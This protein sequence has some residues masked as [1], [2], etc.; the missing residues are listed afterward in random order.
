MKCSYFRTHID[1]LFDCDTPENERIELLRHSLECPECAL[2]YNQIESAAKIVTPR[3][4]V[5]ASASLKARILAAAAAQN[6]SASEQV[7]PRPN[8]PRK[9]WFA[10]WYRPL[11]AVAACILLAVLILNPGR[12]ARIYAAKTLFRNAA[13]AL[14]QSG[15]FYM[16]L[17][18]RTRPGE[19][20]S[21]IN[22]SEPFVRHRMWVVPGIPSLWRLDK[23]GRTAYCDGQQIRM[24]DT[25][26]RTGWI[27]PLSASAI[28]D[29]TLLLDPRTLL[30]R[31]E[32]LAA[33]NPRAAY[34]K[35]VGADEVRLTVDTPAKGD[36]ANDRLLNS[37][38]TESDS[39]RDYRFDRSTGRLT[40]ITISQKFGDRMIPVVE[41]Q[42]ID[43]DIAIPDSLI[44]A[45][46]R[47]IEW[48]DL[49]HPVGGTHFAD[50]T[51]QEAARKM[52][53]AM[54][55]WD[56]QVLNQVLVY[57]SL[58]NL[59][60]YAGCRLLEMKPAF[61]SGRYSGVFVP[62]LVALS[63]GSTHWIDLALRN[64]NPTHSWVA[65]GGI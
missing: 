12:Q 48:K 37:S 50:I 32:A 57:Y 5:R 33:K 60:R 20:F 1:R 2:Y 24:W 44:A 62:C 6:A 17:D 25:V 7:P 52:F 34:T 13:A 45:L 3:C 23:G 30:L 11:A 54:Q 49:T 29:F 4:E 42:R 63:D 41:L 55:V 51:A 31:E 58:D 61:R 64:D 53:G 39:R 35:Q 59:K 14:E 15:P 43:Y 22:A 18:V 56:E 27:H 19:N 10:G 8:M 40:G 46:P 65:D 36:F 47:D 26:A 9:K 21:Y 16:E 38:V 28:E